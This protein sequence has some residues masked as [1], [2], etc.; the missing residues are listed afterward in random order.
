[1]KPLFK[2]VLA[3][4]LFSV[5]I[6][7]CNKGNYNLISQNRDLS[8]FEQVNSSGDFDVIICHD[9][10]FS[11]T[12]EAEE[13]LLRF[14]KTETESGILY[15]GIKD[16]KNLKPHYPI[17]VTVHMPSLTGIRLSGSG[18]ISCDT[19][20]EQ[21][22]DADLS[23]SGNISFSV[24]ATKIDADIS[25][26]GEI[27]IAGSARE[28]KLSISGSGEFEALSLSCNTCYADITGSGNMYV[29]VSD[30]LQVHISGSGN[31]YYSG[32]PAINT[33]ITGSGRVIR[34]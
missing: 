27:K 24:H 28:A 13:N 8:G 6:T 3:G 34:Y 18:N 2:F 14:I 11:V 29:N 22:M 32:N 33:S 12:V 30:Q 7:S 20:N 9:S 19:F 15:V 26:S 5:I 10:L 25:G 17:K 1:M 16:H 21:Q 31:V 23:G 4:L